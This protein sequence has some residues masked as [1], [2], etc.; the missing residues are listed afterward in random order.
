MGQPLT[1]AALLKDAVAALGGAEIDAPAFEARALLSGV[2]GLSR[3]EMLAR[4]EQSIDAGA[5][6]RFAHALGRRAGGEPLARITGQREFWSLPIGLGADTLIPRPDSETVVEAALALVAERDKE[7]SILDLGT[8]SGCLLFAFLAE[9]PHA[10]GLGIDHAA[11]AISVARD[12][13]C[14]LGFSDRSEFR[15]GDWADGLSGPFDIIVSNPPYVGREEWGTLPTEV[16]DFEPELALIGGWD[17]LSAYR[18]LVPGIKRLLGP[19]GFAVLELGAGQ[20]DKI[21]EICRNSGL[22]LGPV[23]RDL[24]GHRRALPVAGSPI[25]LKNLKVKKKVG[26][27]AIPV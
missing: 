7:H 23:R 15:I 11:G 5:R 22:F 12:N 16:R 20:H 3:E 24:G 19:D 9:L 1:L 4:P 14:R 8:G 18:A 27:K 26:K 6:D 17:G 2:L 21:A 25:N 10:R 13:A